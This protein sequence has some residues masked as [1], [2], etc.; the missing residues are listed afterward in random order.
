MSL[1]DSASIAALALCIAASPQDTFAQSQEPARIGW[2]LG[3]SLSA[4]STRHAVDVFLDAMRKLGY[5][6]GRNLAVVYRVAERGPQEL[7]ALA[8]DL[9]KEKVEVIV[10]D[11]SA[12]TRAA[13]QATKTIPIV[14]ALSG[15]PVEQ[16]FVQSL[17]RPGGNITG[18]STLI[19][20]LARKRLELL[21]EMVP[22]AQRVAILRKATDPSMASPPLGL[23]ATARELG[24]ELIPLVAQGLDPDYEHLF[25]D[26][27][28]AG[29]DG[30][31]VQP[32][33]VFT[34]DRARIVE[35]AAKRRLPAIY[36]ERMFPDIG[37][38]MSYGPD[39]FELFRR[40]AERV[41]RIL[42]GAKP[43]D[44]PVEQ[45]DSYDLVINMQTARDLD[46]DVPLS[47]RLRAVP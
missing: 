10:T 15:A 7:P 17:G 18:F 12:A 23:E 32:E 25:D 11:G 34:E 37:G 1:G 31:V 40:A 14:M 47:L 27:A 39:I 35:L 13:Q 29:A 3:Q 46:L 19:P 16:G 4:T 28:R 36:F 22:T 43:G 6:E 41:D 42:K 26:A 5:V 30:M 9:V 2:L 20:E 45:V 33:G 8:A 38:L 44:I 21:K 24:V